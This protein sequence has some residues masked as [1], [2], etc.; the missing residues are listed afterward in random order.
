MSCY[1][2]ELPLVNVHSES[3]GCVVLDCPHCHEIMAVPSI[4][5]HNLIDDDLYDLRHEL[6]VIANQ[7]YGHGMYDISD[8]ACFD[9]GH[10]TLIAVKRIGVD[11]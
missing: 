10:Y 8:H 3:Y 11:E 7:K 1:L 9:S 5:K 4:H 6:S 2:C